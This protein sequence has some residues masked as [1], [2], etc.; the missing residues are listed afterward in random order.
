MVYFN[1]DFNMLENNTS[2]LPD[3]PLSPIGPTGPLI[4]AAPG[5]P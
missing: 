3:K 1:M 5:N 2:V 4:P